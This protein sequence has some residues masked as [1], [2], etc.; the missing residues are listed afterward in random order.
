VSGNRSDNDT[1]CT[2]RN[3]AVREPRIDGYLRCSVIAYEIAS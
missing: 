2:R 3:K 1:F